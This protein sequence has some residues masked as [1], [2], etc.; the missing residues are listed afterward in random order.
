MGTKFFSTCSTNC[1][2]LQANFES[3][4]ETVGALAAG[5]ECVIRPRWQ[6]LALQLCQID[7]LTV[8]QVALAEWPGPVRYGASAHCAHEFNEVQ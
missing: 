7:R 1:I 3:V 5:T 6:V 8:G 2:E 4:D